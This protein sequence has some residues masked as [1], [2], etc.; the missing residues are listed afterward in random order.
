MKNFS[1]RCRILISLVLLPILVSSAEA[2]N[3]LPSSSQ[4]LVV[5][6]ANWD[7]VDEAL[8]RFERLSSGKWQP[9]GQAVHVVVGKSGLAWGAGLIP[10]D[11]LKYPG[12]SDP[13]KK[14]GDRK[15]PAGV[16]HLSSTFGYASEK[17][18]GWKMPYIR[19]APSVVCVDDPESKFYNQI[20]NNSQVSQDWNSAEHML[21]D[22]DLYRW[23]V[24][25][26]HNANP[27][28]P[29]VGSCIFLHIWDGPGQGTVGCTAMARD[30]LESILTWLDPAKRPVL[31][32]LPQSQYERVR[33]RLNLPY[34]WSPAK[35]PSPVSH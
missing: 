35:P 33:S 14:E 8:Y 7:A 31:V 19:L 24:V 12:G 5:T 28:K 22:D 11:D 23:G 32:Q 20:V 2:Q 15:A 30:N 21:R 6:T 18:T 34:V 29:G 4:L 25:V 17:I 9:V 26:D 16:F 27:A 10:A 1:F 13:I 3:P